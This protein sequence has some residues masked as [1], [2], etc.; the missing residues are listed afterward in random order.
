MKEWFY[1]E[2]V[3]IGVDYT[4]Q[5]KSGVYD[6]EMESVRDY[7][8]ET[9]EVIEKLGLADTQSL[10]AIDI[11]CGTGA[12]ALC[13]AKYFQK[14]IAVD[15][16][17]QML[18]VAA[19]KAKEKKIDNI[20]FVHSGFL[21]CRVD[22]PIDVIHSK[23]AFHHLPD[24]WKQA[25]L[26]NVNKMLKN[27][28]L[29]F[30]SDVVFKFDPDFETNIEKAMEGLSKQFGKELLQETRVHIKEEFSTFDWVLEGMFK[31]AGFELVHSDT[32]NI[33]SSEFLCK[34][35]RSFGE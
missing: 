30:L 19:A 18:D 16:S 28:G 22:Q 24:Y 2:F 15:V 13:A 25:A 31:R 32:D 33:F 1:D 7:E 4:L 8:K 29:F 17:R 26:L 6:D 9:K 12:F 23:W 14:I 10:T 11:G 34:K 35:I 27:G 3:Q 20:E 5:E 21:N